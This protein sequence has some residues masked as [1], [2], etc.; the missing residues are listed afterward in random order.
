MFRQCYEMDSLVEKNALYLGQ[1]YLKLGKQDEACDAF[2]VSWKMGE[3][4]GAE[5]YR[6]HCR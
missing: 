6:R 5:A 2:R 3:K 1:V 4:E